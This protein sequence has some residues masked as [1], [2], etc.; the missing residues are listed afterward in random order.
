MGDNLKRHDDEPR[1]AYNQHGDVVEVGTEVRDGELFLTFFSE[2]GKK[3]SAS[4][5]ADQ[6]WLYASD[7]IS[8]AMELDPGYIEDLIK[9]SIEKFQ[10]GDY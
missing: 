5:P 3:G 4:M 1:K 10:A 2:N 6:A 7:I 8:G 9:E